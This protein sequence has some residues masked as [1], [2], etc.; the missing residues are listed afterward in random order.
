MIGIIPGGMLVT[1]DLILDAPL[2]PTQHHM[3]YMH[4]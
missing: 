4:E 2:S 3:H 1:S